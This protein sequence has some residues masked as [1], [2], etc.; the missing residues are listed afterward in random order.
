MPL[1]WAIIEAAGYLWKWMLS[2]VVSVHASS[3]K[4]KSEWAG[5]EIETEHSGLSNSLAT[6]EKSM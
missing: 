3:S 1:D 6:K 4:F 2:R 5:E